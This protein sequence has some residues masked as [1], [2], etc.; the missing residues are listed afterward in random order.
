M[1]KTIH[2][3]G[4]EVPY[5]L[6]YKNVKH[7]NLRIRT[8]GSIHVSANRRH[9]MRNIEAVFTTN[10]EMVLR[11]LDRAAELREKAESIPE[12]SRLKE[13]RACETA[14]SAALKR[15]YPLFASACG[16][17]PEI[18]YRRMKSRWGSCTPSKRL[19]TFNTRLA[20]VPEQCVEYVVVH[21]FCHFMVPDHSAR[22]YQCVASVLP[23]WH[24]RRDEIRKYEGIMT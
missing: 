19:L 23:D 14:V 15:Y 5:E 1:Q 16:G 22:F 24:A 12:F 7:I 20:Y 6:E 4:R 18:R 11:S 2:I 8:D 3:C 10:A 17:M 13:G 9:S 21:E